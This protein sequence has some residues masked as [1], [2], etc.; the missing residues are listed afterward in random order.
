MVNLFLLPK[1]WFLQG[2]EGPVPVSQ[3]GPQGN[4]AALQLILDTVHVKQ[5]SIDLSIIYKL[6]M[7]GDYE[8]LYYLLNSLKLFKEVTGMFD[9]TEGENKVFRSMFT[10]FEKYIAEHKDELKFVPPDFINSV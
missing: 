5:K 8:K 1:R 3:E 10:V 2:E 9:F 7:D 4:V 6:L